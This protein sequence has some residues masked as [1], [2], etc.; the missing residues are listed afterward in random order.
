MGA[1]TGIKGAQLDQ[2]VADV[3]TLGLVKRR[4]DDPSFVHTDERGLG[5]RQE[6]K[7]A[8]GWQGWLRWRLA[9]SL[10]K[11]QSLRGHPGD[12]HR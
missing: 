2:V 10:A 6:L 12:T 11:P 4:V 9:L 7:G 8:A 1:R 3:V 5:D